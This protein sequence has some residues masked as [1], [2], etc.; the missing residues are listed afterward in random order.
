ML[1][2]AI[3]FVVTASIVYVQKQEMSITGKAVEY[4]IELPKPE[5]SLSDRV[6][7]LEQ[8]VRLLEQRVDELVR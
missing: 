1:W 6:N 4:T 3:I 5:L 2:V 8:R 7:F